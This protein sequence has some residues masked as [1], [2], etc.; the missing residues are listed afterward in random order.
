MALLMVKE[1]SR[2]SNGFGKRLKKFQR[3][4]FL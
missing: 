2:H 4:N 1:R 3:A